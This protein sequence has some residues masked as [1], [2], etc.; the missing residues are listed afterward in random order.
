[1]E[2][3]NSIIRAICI[4]KGRGN[5][6]I[7]DD[8]KKY[9]SYVSLRTELVNLVNEHYLVRIA[10]GVYFFP[11]LKD[12]RT[13]IMPTLFEIMDWFVQ[14]E[15][16]ICNPTIEA[17]MYLVGLSSQKPEPLVFFTN[18]GK[19]R[20]SLKQGEVEC[21][22]KTTKKLVSYSSSM[23]ASLVVAMEDLK[24]S[25][26]TDEQLV[27][28]RNFVQTIPM[29]NIERDKLLIPNWIKLRFEIPE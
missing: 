4:K 13:P 20:L 29:E 19:R 10:R 2:S 23:V 12:G 24:E 27:T 15:G 7:L 25:E 11:Q 6:F 14:T 18:R 9:V 16:I 5:F 17:A 22:T 8:F 3:F 28:I 26:M 1:M 21:I